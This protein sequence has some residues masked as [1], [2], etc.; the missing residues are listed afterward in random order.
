VDNAD[1]EVPLDLRSRPQ[2]GLDGLVGACKVALA[3]GTLPAAGGLRPQV[4]VTIDYR[5]LLARLGNITGAANLPGDSPKGNTTTGLAFQPGAPMA[6]TGTMLFTG[7]VTASTV[8][9]IACDADIIPVLLGGEGRILD[10]G[11]AS[12][13]FPPHI[14]QALTARDQGCAF[15]GCTIPAPWCEA[16]HINYWSRGG[17]TGTE[18]GTLLCSHHHHV[19]HKEQ[20]TIQLRTGIP[21]FIPPPHIDP[22]QKPRRNYYFHPADLNTA[23]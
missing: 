19:I 23:A 20:W 14:R 21:W 9:K 13:V 4:M 15:P 3:A 5:D 11:R 2:K 10:I 6:H 18:N 7:P 17:T 22:R 16:H 12:R 1:V 8:R